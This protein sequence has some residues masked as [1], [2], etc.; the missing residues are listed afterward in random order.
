MCQLVCTRSYGIMRLQRAKR[1]T[2]LEIF[3]FSS[4]YF[5][6]LDILVV[7]S[8]IE[9]D[10][11]VVQPKILPPQQCDRNISVLPKVI[12]DC[13]QA[14]FISQRLPRVG[15]KLGN[16]QLADLIGDGLSG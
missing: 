4:F 9:R 2:F 6:Y 15:Q 12:V 16:L 13:A 3:F 5:L 1:K 10:H 7:R 14:E 8:S 11:F